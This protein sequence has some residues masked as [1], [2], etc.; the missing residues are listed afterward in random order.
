M[1]LNDFFN[2]TYYSQDFFRGLNLQVTI[3]IF[4]NS[5]KK[6][7][8]SFGFRNI[9]KLCFLMIFRHYAK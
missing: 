4:E 8:N 6:Q 3:L 9:N 5:G 1:Q 2:F 7:K